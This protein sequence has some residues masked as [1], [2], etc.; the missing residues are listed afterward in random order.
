MQ[1]LGLTLFSVK[2]LLFYC[3][4]WNG[5]FRVALFQCVSVVGARRPLRLSLA[6]TRLLLTWHSIHHKPHRLRRL[7]E[8]DLSTAEIR[9]HDT[10]TTA[11]LGPGCTSF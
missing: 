6:P 10:L 3:I 1:H 4:L 11:K 8:T 7:D 2:L 5:S 9:G